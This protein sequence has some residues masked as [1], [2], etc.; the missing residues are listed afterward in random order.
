MGHVEEVKQRLEAILLLNSDPI[1]VVK[2]QT[3]RNINSF[4]AAVLLTGQAQYTRDSAALLYVDR[5]YRIL[6]LFRAIESGTEM[7]VEAAMDTYF[8]SI[9]ELL[10]SRPS[11]TTTGN[12]DPLANVQDSYLIDDSGVL[13]TE[14]A[15]INYVSIEFTLRVRSLFERDLGL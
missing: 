9:R 14:L 11:L 3:L 12:T 7:A 13:V 6:I 1:R 4:P 15:G 5:D 10:D 2:T 8:D